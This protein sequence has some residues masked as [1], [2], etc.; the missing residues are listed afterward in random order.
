MP[1]EVVDD[2]D[3]FGQQ[4]LDVGQVRDRRCGARVRELLLDV[5]H[6]VVAEVAGEAAAEARQPGP[7]R[8]LEALLECCDEFER[9]AFVRLDDL[10]VASRPRCD[11]PLRA[12]QRARRQADERIAAEALAADHRFEQEAELRAV[13]LALRELEVERERRFEVGEAPRRSA[14]CGCSLAS[15]RLLNSSSVMF[16]SCT[17]SG[18]GVRR[19]KRG[20]ARAVGAFVDISTMIDTDRRRRFP[21]ARAA[22]FQRTVVLCGVHGG[23]NQADAAKP[24]RRKNA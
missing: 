10:A 8:D 16:R 1:D 20:V 11:T 7:Q 24:D 23:R 15:P 19:T 2:G 22:G 5:A 14:E 9:I 6:R 3:F 21:S 12:Q 13:A 4:Q 17:W 18:R